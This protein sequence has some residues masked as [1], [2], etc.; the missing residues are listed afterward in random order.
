MLRY[1]DY[2]S[3]IE[4]EEGFLPIHTIDADVENP[5][6]TKEWRN[7]A[8]NEEDVAYVK[9]KKD[10]ENTDDHD[11]MRI[12]GDHA[13]YFTINNEPTVLYVV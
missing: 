1:Q 3:I 6:C 9:S 10:E 5:V 7:R 2:R 8:I 11:R 4:K 13:S 12:L